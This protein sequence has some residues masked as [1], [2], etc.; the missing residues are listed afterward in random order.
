MQYSALLIIVI[1][2]LFSVSLFLLLVRHI[3]HASFLFGLIFIFFYH[4]WLPASPVVLEPAKTLHEKCLLLE[5][6]VY[7]YL[8]DFN[9]YASTSPSGA[10]V[11]YQR[12]PCPQKH[13]LP[14]RSET[15]TCMYWGLHSIITTGC[16]TIS[17]QTHTYV[18]NPESLLFPLCLFVWMSARQQCEVEK[19]SSSSSSSSSPFLL[20]FFSPQIQLCVSVFP[21]NCQY[22]WLKTS[23]WGVSL[24]CAN[25]THTSVC[26]WQ[27]FVC[28]CVPND[29]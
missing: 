27:T 24:S 16:M 23:L 6:T 18:C 25:Q 29:V 15:L 8:Y 17:T 1:I 11:Y 20:L 14:V 26:W 5:P 22:I 3:F 4:S 13:T 19:T 2:G 9:I 12:R 21:L 7:L 28:V 10:V